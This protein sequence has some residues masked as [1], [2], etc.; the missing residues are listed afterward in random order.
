M[1]LK[2][3]GRAYSTV[4]KANVD[5]VRVFAKTATVR[6]WGG[7]GGNTLMTMRGQS[8]D[9]LVSSCTCS[10]RLQDTGL[11]VHSGECPALNE[12]WERGLAKEE[13]Q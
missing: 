7:R 5:V 8:L 4:F 9:T 13:S 10:R 12:S 2:A 6:V 1:S 11:G 3:G